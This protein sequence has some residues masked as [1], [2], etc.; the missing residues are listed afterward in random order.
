MLGGVIIDGAACVAETIIDDRF[1]ISSRLNL[2]NAALKLSAVYLLESM[3][4]IKFQRTERYYF[5]AI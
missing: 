4:S 3:S 5:V 2:M 1:E